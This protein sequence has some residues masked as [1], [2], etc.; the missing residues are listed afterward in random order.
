[1]KLRQL[2]GGEKL[3]LDRGIRVLFLQALA[4]GPDHAFRPVTGN[5]GH[6]MPGK[7]ERVFSGTAIEFQDLGTLLKY[8]EEGIP[9]G[10]A[11][12]AADHGA[13]KQLVVVWSNTV[14]SQKRL[15]LNL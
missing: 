10:S 13:S 5:N 14:K 9:Y 8:V 11:L 1:V 12:G 15:V 6:V 3:E 2:L 7:E 4:S